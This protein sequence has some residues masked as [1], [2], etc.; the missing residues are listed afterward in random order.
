MDDGNEVVHYLNQYFGGV[1]GEDKADVGPSIVEGPTG[2]GRA[3][4]AAL[5]DRGEVVATAI[6]GDNYVAENM[7]RAAAEIVGLLRPYRPDVFI[8]GPAFEAGRYGVACGAVSKAVTEN[9][10]IPAVTGMYDDNPGVDLFHKDYCRLHRTGK[11]IKAAGRMA[12]WLARRRA[13]YRHAI[14]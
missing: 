7:A 1:G 11:N 4:Q 3:L 14:G 2:P 6:C 10:A 13:D 8:A 5:G 9:L 12:A